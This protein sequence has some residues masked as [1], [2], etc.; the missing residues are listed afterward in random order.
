MHALINY[1]S[2]RSRNVGAWLRSRCRLR[3]RLDRSPSASPFCYQ[4][5]GI[6]TTLIPAGHTYSKTK[7]VVKK[8]NTIT[9]TQGLHHVRLGLWANQVGTKLWEFEYNPTQSAIQLSPVFDRFAFW[10]PA[11]TV[12]SSWPYFPVSS[13][14]GTSI[15]TALST[16][17][18]TSLRFF[19]GPINCTSGSISCISFF[20]SSA[21]RTSS[22]S[23][24]STF[25]YRLSS[26]SSCRTA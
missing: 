1:F 8:A 23:I 15:S 9:A 22:N 21:P 14:T 4:C 5:T 24:S 11:E 20:T 10:P 16:A 3:W 17:L 2:G 6:I 13:F 12:S 25:G 19:S 26:L 18:G 7:F